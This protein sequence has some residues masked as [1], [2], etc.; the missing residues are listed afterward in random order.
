MQKRMYAAAM[1]LAAVTRHHGVR[2]ILFDFRSNACPAPLMAKKPLL[3]EYYR[4]LSA[5]VTLPV[6][7]R[8]H[9]LLMQR[10]PRRKG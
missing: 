7:T 6:L 3:I 1:L 4:H 2:S 10:L 5:I 9:H 8:R